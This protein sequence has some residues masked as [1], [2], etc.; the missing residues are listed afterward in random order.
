[1]ARRLASVA[2]LAPDYD[3]AIAWF[4]QA[5]GFE[6]I[7]DSDLGAGKRWVVVAPDRHAGARL[8]IA[9]AADARQLAAV[10]E[11]A[12]G[13]VAYFLETDDFARDH[14]AFMQRG[15]KIPRSAAP[16]TLWDR[17]GLRRPLRQQVGL[18][19]TR[20][21]PPMSVERQ[22]LI[23][24]AALGALLASACACSARPSRR[25]R[26]ASR[27]A[28][29]SIRSCKRLHRWG[30]SRLIAALLIL[31]LFILVL[32]LVLVI[33]APIL[34]N[35]LVGFAQRLPGIVTKLQTLA[36]NEGQELA[37]KYGGAWLNS[38]GVTTSFAP[39]QIQKTVSDFVASGA[40]W[41]LGVGRGILSGGAALI[42]F[43]SLLVVTPVVAFYILVDWDRMVQRGRLALA[44]RSSRLAARDR[45]A[46]STRRWPASSAAS[47]LFVCFSACGTASASA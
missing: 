3:S 16:R 11:A 31:A 33:V 25:L 40:Q 41:L 24:A 20:G 14:E 26:R 18:D 44:A 1:M 6:L 45:R 15:R 47:R 13:R 37:E 19:R 10:G 17:R 23:W 22:A 34:A 21:A 27:W 43:F 5:L 39:D 29:C 36:V 7:E 32:A 38:W 4:C 12:G 8:V 9:K 42:S 30:M 2:F 46:R 35:Q 28:T